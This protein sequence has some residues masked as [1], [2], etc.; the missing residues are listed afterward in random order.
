MCQHWRKFYFQKIGELHYIQV[1]SLYWRMPLSWVNRWEKRPVHRKI[2][3]KF[4]K[5]F[6]VRVKNDQI[7]VRS[8]QIHQVV[9]AININNRRILTERLLHAMTPVLEW[10][11]RWWSPS[12][13]VESSPWLNINSNINFCSSVEQLSLSLSAELIIF[14]KNSFGVRLQL[15][16]WIKSTKVRLKTGIGTT[17]K[18]IKYEKYCPNQ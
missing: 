15:S 6:V 4:H 8:P 18:K 16:K 7:W 13:C 1:W 5:Y 9:F 17:T 14:W 12:W 2:K 3:I 10:R 11:F